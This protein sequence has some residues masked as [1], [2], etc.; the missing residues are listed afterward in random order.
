MYYIQ[1]IVTHTLPFVISTVLV[2]ITE[3]IFLETDWF[4]LM[5]TAIVYLFVN[6]TVTLYSGKSSVFF[7][8]WSQVSSINAYSPMVAGGG[9]FIIGLAQHFF[10]AMATQLGNQNYEYQY[11]TSYTGEIPGM[12]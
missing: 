10:L 2:F 1:D 9:F 3:T 4:L 7:L 11:E 5:N 6:W 12:E 8:D